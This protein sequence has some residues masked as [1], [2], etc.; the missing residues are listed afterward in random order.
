MNN[1]Q[2]IHKQAELS[3]YTI[4]NII[5]YLQDNCPDKVWL[6]AAM[7]ELRNVKARQSDI[8]DKAKNILDTYYTNNNVPSVTVTMMEGERYAR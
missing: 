2:E 8:M 3:K 1:A 5:A 6:D 4:D 7:N